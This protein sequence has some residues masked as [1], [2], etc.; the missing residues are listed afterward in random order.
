MA[1]TR[2]N[3]PEDLVEIGDIVDVKVIK[4]DDKGRIDASMKALLPKPEG[5]VE[6]EKRERS[7]KPRRHKDHDKKE[8]KEKKDKNFGEFKFHKVEKK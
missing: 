3:K 6:P 1:W 2:V 4:I 8:H 7:D 5:Y